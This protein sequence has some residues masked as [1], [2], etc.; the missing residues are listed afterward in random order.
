MATDVPGI[1]IVDDNEDN[2]Y[3]LQLMLESDGHER[4]ASAASGNEAIALIEKEKFSLVLLDLM[5][6]DLNGDEV[7]KVIKSDPDKR[8]IP[9]VMISAD[10]DAEKVSQCIELGADDYLPKPFNPTILRA[11]IAAAL[12]R[13][14]LRALE[15][16]YVGKIEN[17]KR[18]SENLLRNILP[19]EIA[20]RLRNGE[21][22]I[23]DHFDDAT[24]IFADVVGFGKITARMKA[25][26]IVACLNQLFSEFDRLAEDAGI[27][28]IKTIGDNYMAV[29]G[30]PT[31]RANHVRMAAKFAL[32]MVAAT[33]RLRSRL[34]VPF[35]I[36]V[37][38]HSG[39]VMAGVIGTRKFAYDVWG[40]TVNIA[41]RLEAAGQPNR[42]LASA[43]TVKGLGSDYSFDGPHKID[44]KE[45]RVLEAFFLNPRP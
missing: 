3:T 18:H 31:P 15:N 9:V 42:V 13:H 37:G 17:E 20:T 32:D 23:A 21:S 19:A 33:A 10:T 43:A 30:V 41:A 29:A 34:P 28:K 16:E 25:Y 7:L 22:N 2:R 11:R 39:P 5:M 14:S 12:R 44:N 4:I 45:E 26:E 40:D 6:P 36:R 1:L 27:E 24:V 38:L 35:S 8:D